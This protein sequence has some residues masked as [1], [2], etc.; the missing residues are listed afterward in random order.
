[1]SFFYLQKPD[2]FNKKFDVVIC[3]M[4]VDGKILF[5]K[6]N[7]FKNL[8]N[9]WAVPGGE[10]EKGEFLKESLK[11]ELKEELTIFNFDDNAIKY[12]SSL[13]VRKKEADFQLHIFHWYLKSMPNIV[14]DP[15][16][17]EKYQW[18]PKDKILELDLLEGQIEAY[19][20][21]YPRSL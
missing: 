5:L 17:H 15:N 9:K 13:Y 19:K 7:D 14:L 3:F 20:L 4:E 11:R 8:S 1:M 18:Q 16:E 10:V 2:N 6:R 21:I 12:I